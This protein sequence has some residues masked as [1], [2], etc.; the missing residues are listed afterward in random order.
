MIKVFCPHCNREIQIEDENT[1]YIL[2]RINSSIYQC[3]CQKKF[4]IYYYDENNIKTLRI[5]RK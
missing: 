2:K 3:K 4:L 5:S 1:I